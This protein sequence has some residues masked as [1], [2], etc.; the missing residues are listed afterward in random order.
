[1]TSTD[2]QNNENYPATIVAYRHFKDTG[3]VE[4]AWFYD[5]CDDTYGPVYTTHP[6]SPHEMIQP[7]K[8]RD[9]LHMTPESALEEAIKAQEDQVRSAQAKLD[10]E[11][12][13]L[14]H[15]KGQIGQIKVT[16][17]KA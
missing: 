11:L 7:F 3:V 9:Q 10:R 17:Y 12:G 14:D 2:A 15:L 5:C 1:M 16:E 6:V 13:S 8:Y 4:Q